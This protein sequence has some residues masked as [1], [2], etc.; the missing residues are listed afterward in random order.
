MKVNKFFFTILTFFS[1]SIFICAA[2]SRISSSKFYRTITIN[3]LSQGGINATFAAKFTFFIAILLLT[4]ILVG[5]I[6]KKIFKLPTVAGQIIGGILLGPSLINIK[7]IHFF[8]QPLQFIDS[9]KHQ[10]YQI[11]SSD[12]FFFFILLISSAITVAYL[13]WLAGHETDVADMA[14][15]GLESTLAGILGAIVPILI[16]TATAF[17]LFGAT[18]SL[19]T[20]IGLGVVFSATSVSIP[21][22]MLISQ[23]KMN[24]RSSKAT[25]GAAIVDDI[26]AVILFS[27]FIVL[28]QGGMLGTAHSFETIGHCP[29][30]ANSLA[31]MFITFLIMFLFG[32][33]IIANITKMLRNL[34]M[35]HV[36]PSFATLMMLSY[37][38]LAELLGG[39]AGI[40][41]AYFAGFFHRMVDTRHKA[42]RAVSP[43]VNTILLPIFLGSIGMQV[44]MTLLKTTDWLIVVALL[45]A[46]IISKL[47]GCQIT[48]SFSNLF[49]KNKK[50]KWS[51]LESYL[52]GSSMIARGEV[53]LVIATI[54][55]GT[56]LITPT[57]YVI[58]VTVIVLT[59][60]ASPIML[61]IG[62]DLLG[63]KEKP[64]EKEFCMRIGPFKYLSS[65]YIFDVISDQLEREEKVTPIVALSEGKKILNLEE[66]NVEIILEPEKGIV[67]RGDEE[68]IR[69]ILDNLRNL[70]AHDVET[71]PE[72]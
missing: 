30:I 42:V 13:L 69:E 47:A 62:F 52:F 50:Q 72:M 65:R 48:T 18:Y 4:T 32:R 56:H 15:V 2:R 34:R 28:L 1:S 29:G 22:A 31:Y 26:L 37:F 41:G 11:A 57:Q 54:L 58:C 23:N 46:A 35:S 51:F 66:R 27:I 68:K 6:L 24:L 25:M 49:I 64:A 39:L 67:F 45:F 36:I 40:T 9:A 7:E 71:I 17:Y 55:N 3:N 12:L 38:S 43:F 19:A 53:G 44:D 60:I 8:T 61:S 21:I 63:K 14:K 20:S 70:L 33:Y 10:I 5:K 16:I 59:T